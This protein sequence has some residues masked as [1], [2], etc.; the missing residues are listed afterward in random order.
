MQYMVYSQ[1]SKEV[2]VC[3]KTHTCA[4]STP[5]NARKTPCRMQY[6]VRRG[7]PTLAGSVPLRHWWTDCVVVVLL[8]RCCRACSAALGLPRLG[9]QRRQLAL[10][11]PGH[12]GVVRGQ[13][14][15]GSQAVPRPG[16]P[17]RGGGWAVL[18][19]AANR[20]A[21]LG[22]HQL[23][24]YPVFVCF[25]CT[26]MCLYDGLLIDYRFFADLEWAGIW[27]HL[28]QGES[29][30]HAHTWLDPLAFDSDECPR[31]SY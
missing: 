4:V 23:E 30:S 2:E 24:K 12:H 6:F 13:V 27:H 14:D 26:L 21:A 5:L 15:P 29:E 28:H 31:L 22:L 1:Y 16:H 25:C 20:I 9:G 11:L 18:S 7:W 17:L 10:Q 19:S 3:N 8:C